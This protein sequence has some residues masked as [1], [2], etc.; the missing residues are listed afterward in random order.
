MTRKPPTYPVPKSEIARLLKYY[1]Q[2]PFNVRK[3]HIGTM[4]LGAERQKKEWNSFQ[5]R[6]DS[7]EKAL[8]KKGGTK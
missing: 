7:L 6:I 4:K 5:K 8:A 1:E 2:L 3:M